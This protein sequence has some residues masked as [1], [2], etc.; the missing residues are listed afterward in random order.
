MNIVEIDDANWLV[1]VQINHKVFV[2]PINCC[3]GY[4]EEFF[5]T[6]S[7]ETLEEIGFEFSYGLNAY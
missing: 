4:P 3:L 7:E 2:A 5:A 6:A 1:K